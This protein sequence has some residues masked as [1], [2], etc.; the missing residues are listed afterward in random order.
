MLGLMRRS[1]L[2]SCRQSALLTYIQ[3]QAIH[4]KAF[5]RDTGYAAPLLWYKAVA[6]NLFLPDKS[7]E[8]MSLAS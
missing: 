7:G 5:G 8:R 4:K 6:E 1:K 3:D 2:Y